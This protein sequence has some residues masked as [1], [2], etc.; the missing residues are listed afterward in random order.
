M[1][2]EVLVTRLG[3]VYLNHKK[4]KCL[5]KTTSNRT[6]YYK[7]TISHGILIPENNAK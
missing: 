2:T 3:R 5:K 1:I 7:E 6:P 4:Q